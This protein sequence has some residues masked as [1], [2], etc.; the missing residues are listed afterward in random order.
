M[1]G[2]VAGALHLVPGFFILV[3]GL[4]APLWAVLAMGVGWLLLAVLLIRLVQA[5]SWWSLAVPFATAAMWFAVLWFGGN[6]LG[7]TA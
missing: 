7:W 1:A 3:S 2:I 6:V 5:R 4:V